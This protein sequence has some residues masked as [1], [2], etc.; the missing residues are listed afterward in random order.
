MGRNKGDAAAGSAEAAADT[1]A[2]AL[3]AAPRKRRRSGQPEVPLHS[4]EDLL[5]IADRL[6]RLVQRAG[7]YVCDACGGTFAELAGFGFAHPPQGE[8]Q[9]V[10]CS[11][12]LAW[13]RSLDERDRDR[14]SAAV[15]SRLRVRLSRTMPVTM[16]APSRTG[17]PVAGAAAAAADEPE[18][19]TR[20]RVHAR[21][22][23]PTEPTPGSPLVPA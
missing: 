19:T 13:G 4:L 12:C 9:Y 14:F 23:P 11:S 17:A 16:P 5:A 18:P 8:L 2:A 3:A 22:V 7:G 15:W 21:P 6:S 20:H 10:V 1:K